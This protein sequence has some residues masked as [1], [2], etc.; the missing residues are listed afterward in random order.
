MN[1]FDKFYSL[2]ISP[3]LLIVLSGLILFISGIRENN[4]FF[5]VRNIF[6]EQ[7]SLFE[8]CKE[9]LVVFYLVPAFLSLAITQIKSIDMTIINNLNIVLAIF[10]S[11]LFAML[12]IISSYKNGTNKT[13]NKVLRET[14]NSIIFE[15]VLCIIT[16]IVS[17]VYLFMDGVKNMLLIKIFSFVEYYLVFV[18][19]LNIFVVIKRMKVLYDN[20]T[21]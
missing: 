21:E 14:F 3:A 7:F 11:M 8:S 2:H 18:F 10:T 1:L 20:K 17:F 19:L 4:N 5:D 13:Y 15:I 16:L 12:S 6:K 9:Q